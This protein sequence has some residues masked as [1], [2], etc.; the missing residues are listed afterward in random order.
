[1]DVIAS[2]KANAAPATPNKRLPAILILGLACLCLVQLVKG[3]LDAGEAAR[4]QRE[5][6][7]PRATIDRFHN[8]FYNSPYTIGANRWMGIKTV[9]NPNDTWITQEILFEVKPDFLVE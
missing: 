9:Q 8:L 4:K 3:Q 7:S 6:T 1:M 5:L 2:P